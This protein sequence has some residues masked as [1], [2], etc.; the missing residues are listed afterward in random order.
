MCFI[1]CEHHRQAVLDVLDSE[2]F[3]LDDVDE[4]FEQQ[5]VR[6]LYHGGTKGVLCSTCRHVD[7]LMR[8]FQY[9]EADRKYK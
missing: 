2:G 9:S 5:I 4:D 7:N 3:S 8:S 1:L 6:K